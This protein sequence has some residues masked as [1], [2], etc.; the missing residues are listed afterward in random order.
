MNLSK[1]QGLG[2]AAT[3]FS[4]TLF[5]GGC[6]TASQS[7]ASASS[8]SSAISTKKDQSVIV[9]GI[10]LTVDQF[11][12]KKMVD[13]KKKEQTVF[14]AHVTGK[15]V[16][17]AS[18]GLGAIDFIL[19]TSDGKEHQVS[20]DLSS[21]GND[22]DTAKTIEGDLYFTLGKNDSPKTIEYKPADKVLYSWT[23]K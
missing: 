17:G 23:V 22:I 11:S 4:M 1:K 16:T 19:K 20:T 2:I 7:N 5:L 8:T 3:I 10:E 9:D 13:N 12:Q 21:F 14:T 15:N 6:S 18:K